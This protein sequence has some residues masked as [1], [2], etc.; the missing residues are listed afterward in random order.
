M[1][2]YSIITALYNSFDLMDRYFEALS[3]QT[4]KDFE[5][6]IVDDCSTDDSYDKLKHKIGDLNYPVITLKADYNQGPGNA[7][8][9]GIGKASGEWITFVDNDD[10]VTNDFLQSIDEVVSNNSTN[11]II[12]DYS[13]F[14]NGTISPAESMYACEGG[15]KSV[16]CCIQFVRNHTFGKVYRKSSI[17]NVSFPQIRR[18]ED[19][20][21]VSQAIAACQG[22]Y[23]LP[24]SLYY[25]WQRPSS[26][27]KKK[28]MDESDLVKAFSILEQSLG[29]SYPHEIKE[30]S[31]CDLLYGGVLI[32]CKAGKSSKSIKDYIHNYEG[33]YSAWQ[34]CEIVNHIGRFKK[35]YLSLIKHRLIFPIRVLTLI[36]SKITG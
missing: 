23:Y 10:W 16:A 18:C 14:R 17:T 19:I 34:K 15:Y 11:C 6:I 22:A 1:P 3:N 2:K 8:N 9:M 35:I 36:H 28:G 25:Y 29:K 33:R 21:F 13:V 32:M 31:V 30:K 27:S 26:L 4:Y 12:F 5:V 20:A 24:K 7:R